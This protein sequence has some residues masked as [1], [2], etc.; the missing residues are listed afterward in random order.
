MEKR[1][2][3][4][5]AVREG[6]GL[7]VDGWCPTCGAPEVNP[8]LPGKVLIRG[9]KVTDQWDRWYSHCLVCASAAGPGGYSADLL[10]WI[11][12][13]TDEQA[14]YGWFTDDPLPPAVEY[15]QLAKF[16]ETRAMT[17]AANDEVRQMLNE[18]WNRLSDEERAARMRPGGL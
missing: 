5:Q 6:I 14:A 1:Y 3:P 9:Y 11:G 12:P 17:N 13:L 2:D 10:T 18:I 16:Y 8:L 15:D 7:P 4:A